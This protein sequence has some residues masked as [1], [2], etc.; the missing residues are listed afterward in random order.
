MCGA[1]L[2]LLITIGRDFFLLFDEPSEGN[3]DGLDA[4]GTGFGTEM[5]F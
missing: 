2:S 1:S 5:E 3:E 4:R